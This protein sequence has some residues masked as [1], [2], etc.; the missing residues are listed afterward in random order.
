M[1]TQT[2]PGVIRAHEG[3]GVPHALTR[4]TLRFS[5]FQN[6]GSKERR[7]EKKRTGR[8]CQKVA[9]PRIDRPLSITPFSGTPTML[10]R[11]WNRRGL[12]VDAPMK[13]DAKA[14]RR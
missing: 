1:V 13:T 2:E 11:M 9:T 10:P 14:F 5:Q 8:Y 12:S 7:N 3:C 4:D 6:G